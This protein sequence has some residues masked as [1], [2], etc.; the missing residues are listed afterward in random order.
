[1]R[2]SAGP[3]ETTIV[4]VAPLAAVSP[5]PGL[6]RMTVPLATESEFSV[7]DFTVK[8]LPSSVLRALD[9]E[10]PTTLGTTTDSGPL[11]R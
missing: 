3:A 11:E 1:M 6:V 9:S 5:L 10:S 7:V 2:L 8:P 4:T